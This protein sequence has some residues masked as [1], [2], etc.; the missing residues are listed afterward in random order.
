MSPKTLLSVT[1]GTQVHT[2]THILHLLVSTSTVESLWIHFSCDNTVRLAENGPLPIFKSA[3]S[4]FFMSSS[5]LMC[6]CLTVCRRSAGFMLTLGPPVLHKGSYWS[7]LVGH[8]PQF[9]PSL[10]PS[11]LLLLLLLLPCLRPRWDPLPGSWLR[12]LR[13]HWCDTAP[14]SRSRAHPRPGCHISRRSAA[15]APPKVASLR[16][17]RGLQPRDMINTQHTEFLY[18]LPLWLWKNEWEQKL[19]G[20]CTQILLF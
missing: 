1:Q 12:S 18:I 16:M 9:C 3:L 7:R 10:R 15:P 17:Q 14:P 11:L 5:L 20:E 6:F 4:K 2:Q 8:T 19:K 13:R